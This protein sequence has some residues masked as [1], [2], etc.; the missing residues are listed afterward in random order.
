MLII[1]IKRHVVTWVGSMTLTNGT[2]WSSEVW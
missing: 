2:E 1:I